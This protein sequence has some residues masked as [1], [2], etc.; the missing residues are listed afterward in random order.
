MSTLQIGSTGTA[1][2]DLQLDL[3]TLNCL[4]GSADGIFGPKT[5]EAL[6]AFKTSHR[7]E[8][9]DN[10]AD[11]DTVASV[12]AAAAA[13]ESVRVQHDPP[14]PYGHVEAVFGKFAYVEADGGLVRVTDDWASKHLVRADLPVVGYQWVHTLVAPIITAVLAEIQAAGLG[15]EIKQFGCYNPRHQMNDPKAP[16]SIHSW[17][18]AFDINQKTNMPGAK[19]D[20]NPKIV[21]VFEK[22][23]FTWGGRFKRSDPMHFQYARGC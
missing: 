10:T 22:H 16:L 23:G 12:H 3:I 2:A 14:P 9:I 4:S 11:D 8:I 6:Q 13:L 20:M 5:G 1:V 7:F 15:P 19:G 18:V 21:A 17:A